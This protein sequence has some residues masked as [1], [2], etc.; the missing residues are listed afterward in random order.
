MSDRAV[1][2]GGFT[3]TSMWIDPELDLYVIFLGDRL[4]PD[5]KGVIVLTRDADRFYRTLN[6]IALE[7]LGIE[8][9][10]PADDTVK[11]VYEYLIGEEQ[12]R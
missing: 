10:A 7:E 11:S 3:G 12:Q 1:G 4:H 9:I 6:H 5:G 2:H 8:S